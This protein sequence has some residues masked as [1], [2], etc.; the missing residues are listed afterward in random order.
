MKKILY[1]VILAAAVCS[2][3]K[4]SRYLTEF[5]ATVEDFTVK[6]AVDSETGVF[7]WNEGDRIKV[8][9]GS[10][11]AIFSYDLKSGKFVSD[12]GLERTEN[13]SAVYPADA[14]TFESGAIRILF[15]DKQKT[16]GKAIQGIPLYLWKVRGE[17]FKFKSIAG[18]AR[19][20]LIGGGTALYEAP[21]K[22]LVFTSTGNPV[23]GGGVFNP[24]DASIAM[25]GGSQ[26]LTVECDPSMTVS[27]SVF[28]VLPAQKYPMGSKVEIYFEDGKVLES[29]TIMGIVP[30]SGMIKSYE[31]EVEADFFGPLEDYED[32]EDLDN[33]Y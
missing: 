23:A 14:G 8:S 10:H 4:E 27:S 1:F 12:S 16:D 29:E 7:S 18:V 17:V 5:T 13:Y 21:M 22:K 28:M 25:N 31:I 15:A 19:I 33:R 24:A 26:S 11:E 32:G 20:C 3:S 9:N 30:R 6:S 2:C